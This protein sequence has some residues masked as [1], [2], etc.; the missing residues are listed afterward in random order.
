MWV[1][2]WMWGVGLGGHEPTSMNNLNLLMQGMAEARPL[3]K[4]NILLKHSLVLCRL[5]LLS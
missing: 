3:H 4:Q 1:W 5:L 2:V